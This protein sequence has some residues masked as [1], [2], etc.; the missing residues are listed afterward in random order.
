MKDFLNVAEQ[1]IEFA[2]TG[3]AVASFETGREL[4]NPVSRLISVQAIWH[5]KALPTFSD[6]LTLVRQY[7]WVAYPTFTMSRQEPSMLKIP[8]MPYDTLVSTLRYAA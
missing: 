1:V 7:L 8:K 4:S 3:I 2:F 6:A 5:P